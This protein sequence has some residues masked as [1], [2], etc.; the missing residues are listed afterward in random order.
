MRFESLGVGFTAIAMLLPNVAAA[1]TATTTMGVSANVQSACVVTSNNLSFGNYNPTAA[2]PTDATS[3]FNVTCTTGT[4][5]TVGLNAGTTSGATVTTRQMANGASSLGYAL[6]SDAA[7]KI[8]AHNYYRP[9]K[10]EAADPEDLKRFAALKLVTVDD[11][12]FGGWAKV[13]PAHFADGA[14]FDQIYKP[15]Q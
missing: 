1:S 15:G 10:P 11:P 12:Q 4:S 13:Q 5:F 3:T 2:S 9:V 8:I 6:Y 7:Q 14:I